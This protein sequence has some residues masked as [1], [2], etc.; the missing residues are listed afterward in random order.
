[1][2]VQQLPTSFSVVSVLGYLGEVLH[3]L[4]QSPEGKDV[5]D[6]VATLICGSEDGIRWSW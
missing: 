2:D 5:S 3:G 1:M 4:F 6:R